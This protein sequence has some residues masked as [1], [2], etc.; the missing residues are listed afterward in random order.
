MAVI[1][2][3]VTLLIVADNGKEMHMNEEKKHI[4]HTDKMPLKDFPVAMAY[5]PWQTWDKVCDL[6]EGF[7]SGTIFPEL[8]KPFLCY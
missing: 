3:N 1:Y 7:E 4:R 8:K 6:D 2:Y 5:V